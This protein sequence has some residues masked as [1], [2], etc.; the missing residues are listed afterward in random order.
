MHI[1]IVIIGCYYFEYIIF[2][3][4][5][6]EICAI[7]DNT[8][9]VTG[10]LLVADISLAVFALADENYGEAWRCTKLGCELFY[11]DLEFLADGLCN[12][13]SINDSW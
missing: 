12:S 2:T 13:F 5:F 6:R 11:F 1:W 7:G 8:N 3:G 9:L 4:I 10:L